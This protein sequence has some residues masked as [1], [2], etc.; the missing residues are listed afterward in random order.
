MKREHAE[1]ILATWRQH[2]YA[3]K[4]L[5]HRYRILQSLYR[6]FD[7]RL[8]VTPLDDVKRPPRPQPRPVS[9]SDATIEAVA[10]ELRKREILGYRDAKTRA[11]FL[12]LA[13]HSQRPAELQRAQPGD[14]DLQR[15]LWFVR[16]AK[17]SYNTTVPLN[18]DQVAAWQLFMDAGAWG[19]YD[20]RSFSKTLKRAGWPKDIR[21]YNLRHSTGRALDERGV[22]LGDIQGL[23]GHTTPETTRAFYVPGMI[24]RLAAATKKLEGRFSGAGFTSRSSTAERPSVDDVSRRQHREK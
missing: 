1:N 13:T 9:V 18:E 11:R 24:K 22:D 21:P 23:M 14:V 19:V 4:T 8:A 15:R 7:G 2:G 6:Y 10:L 3:P 17:G 5:R 20:S 16:G 12:V